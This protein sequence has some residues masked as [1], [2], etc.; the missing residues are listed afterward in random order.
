[1]PIDRQAVLDRL[2]AFDFSGLFTQELGWDWYTAETKVTAA[3]V[4]LTLKGV[5]KKRGVHVFQCPPG[6]DGRL[7]EAAV[8]AAIERQVAKIAAGTCLSSPMP[9]GPN[10]SGS[11]REREWE[12][13]GAHYVI[14]RRKQ[15]W[16][17]PTS[18]VTDL[19]SLRS[20]R[21]CSPLAAA[22]RCDRIEKSKQKQRKHHEPE[23]R[24][25][26]S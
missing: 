25:R 1:M 10:R 9:P 5:A 23:G 2:H 19:Q 3:T 16:V 15:H 7:P 20:T 6:A 8:C 13:H 17:R 12:R 26:C 4:D 22:A 14:S 24:N 11:R 18:R 21:P